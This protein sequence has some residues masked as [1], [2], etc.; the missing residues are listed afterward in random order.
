M[1]IN[2]VMPHQ[3]SFPPQR[4]GGVE[5]LNWM[6]AKEYARTGHE[7]VAYSRAVAGLAPRETDAH[8]IRHIRVE[9]YDLRPNRWVDHYYGWRYAR[10]VGKVLE[11]A[12]ATTFHT[13]FS[14][15][16]A[17]RSDIGVTA[18]TIH[19]TPKWQLA[20]YGSLDRIYAGSNAVVE[21]ARQISPKSKNLK[22]VYNCIVLP[23]E[24]PEYAPRLSS[25]GLRFLYVG[26]F[27]PDKGIASLVEGFAK[28]LAKFPGNRLETIG[29]QFSEQGA[30]SAFFQEMTDYVEKNNLRERVAF[31]PPEFNRAKLDAQLAAADVICVP[32]LTG[33]T[34]SMAILEA[35]ALAKPVLVSDFSPMTEA[36][37]H[38]TTGYIA[39]AGDA[40]S[41][42]EGIEY[43]SARP[44]EL[45]AIGR[46]GFA[47]A[48]RSFSVERIAA[49]YVA[50]FAELIEAKRRGR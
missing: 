2:L 35:M 44:E 12:D 40:A 10:T 13:P 43:C 41:M 4:G 25:D 23:P 3:L 31:L 6:L 15:L 29:P 27:V 28:S 19:R 50:D 24:P 5:N 34:F 45:P 39:R 7:V 22:R 9:G 33:E 46:A 37:D 16:L 38:L 11:S 17:R 32:S 26:R 14:F 30:D 47:K 18:H 49:E 36:T 8:G 48:Q 1:K 21:Q 20:L 42:A